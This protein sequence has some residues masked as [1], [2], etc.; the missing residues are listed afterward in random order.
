VFISIIRFE[1][2]YF[3]FFFSR[4]RA[5]LGLKPLEVNYPAPVRA[6]KFLLFSR[7]FYNISDGEV[8]FH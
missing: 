8:L 4:I 3:I 1:D 5:K 7:L 2:I 6:G